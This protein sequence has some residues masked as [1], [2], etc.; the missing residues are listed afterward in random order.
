HSYVPEILVVVLGHLLNAGLT[1]GFAAAAASITEHPS[2]AAIVT[3]AFTVG[4]W[5]INFIAAVHGGIWERIASYTSSA[6]VAEFQRGLVQ[7]KVILI[8]LLFI[9]A[10]LTI[11]AVWMRLGVPI[12]R[13]V[14]E[15]LLIGACATVAVVACTFVRANWDLSESRQNSFPPQ[16]EAILRKIPAPLRI[17]AH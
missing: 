7:T 1:I 3:F 17:E 8:A 9:L 10:G 4:T 2:T 6:M 11:G 15:S 13:R 16:S 12:H 14:L 5:V